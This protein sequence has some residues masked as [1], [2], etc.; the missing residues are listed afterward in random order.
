MYNVFDRPRMAQ[1]SAWV[2]AGALLAAACSASGDGS[3][4]TAGDGDASGSTIEITDESG[5]RLELEVPVE[6]AVIVD[7]WAPQYVRAMGAFDQVVAIDEEALADD[8]GFWDGLDVTAGS[9]SGTL[10]YEQIVALDA[11]VVLIAN[12]GVW[13]EART[14]LAP[15][16]IDVL[17]MTTWDQNDVAEE[18]ETLGALF[19]SEEEA[20]ELIDFYQRLEAELDERLEGVEPV[21][22]YV[23]NEPDLSSPLP[24][25]SSGWHQMIVQAGGENIFEDLDFVEQSPRGAGSVHAFPIDSEAV[26]D[27][28]PELIVKLAGGWY[29]GPEP[30]VLEEWHDTVTSRPGWASIP[31][32]ADNNVVVTSSFPMNSFSKLIGSVYL[33]SW[34]HPERM[35][36]LDPDAVT[37]EW[38]E[39]FQGVDYGDP[40]A[41]RIDPE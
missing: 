22:V 38:I 20:G 14:Q 12:T 41:Y 32:V 5:E 18:F 2:V 8:P 1:A 30:A 17:V 33:A 36:G 15:F 16:D 39:E 26:V 6:R 23:E 3:D 11:D 35:E 34:L 21:P 9:D 28:Q 13:E 25:P 4:G 24:G 27:R 37:V 40:G 19:G 10:D 7:N 29:G 31:A